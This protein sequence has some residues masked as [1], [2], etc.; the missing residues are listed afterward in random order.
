MQIENIE[1]IIQRITNPIQSNMEFNFQNKMKRKTPKIAAYDINGYLIKTYNK[2]TDCIPDG[3]DATSV[4]KCITGKR[5]I[6]NNFIFIRYDNNQEP[7]LKIDTKEFKIRKNSREYK[8]HQILKTI[9]EKSNT[10]PEQNI[11]IPE[12]NRTRIGMFENNG[13]LL[14]VF[15][16]TQELED[17][18]IKA[19]YAIYKQIYGNFTKKLEKGYKGKYQFRR[20]ETGKTYTINKKYNLADIPFDKQKVFF[21]K[22][23]PKQDIIPIE[24]FN[25]VDSESTTLASSPEVQNAIT[26][27]E[28]K[29]NFFQ[30]LVYLFTGK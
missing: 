10:P 17:Y 16:T 29:K 25:S 20:L 30:R 7:R 26:R 1:N 14:K 11:Y 5:K 4:S 3:F 22:N 8:N 2:T 19:R 18:D 15:L 27:E 6:H 23:K 9:I 13:T 28:P 24:N 21:G 12:K